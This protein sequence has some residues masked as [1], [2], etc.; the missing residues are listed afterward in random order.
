MGGV[1]VPPHGQTFF[2]RFWRF[3]KMVLWGPS[4]PQSLKKT[5]ENLKILVGE[6]ISIS[7]DFLL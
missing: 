1:V 6:A 7:L 4:D 3:E 2:W 5:Y